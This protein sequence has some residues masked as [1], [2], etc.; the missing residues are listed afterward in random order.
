MATDAERIAELERQLGETRLELSKA[1][2]AAVLRHIQCPA[3]DSEITSD[4]QQLV[5]K[6]VEL[7]EQ[8]SLAD[9][10]EELIAQNAALVEENTRLKGAPEPAPPA[11]APE[12]APIAAAPQTGRRFSVMTVR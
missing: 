5:K 9:R 7:A 1:R 11:P 6:S 3:C 4:G 10:A 8:E 12:P 2:E